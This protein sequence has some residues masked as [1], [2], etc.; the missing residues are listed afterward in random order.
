MMKQPSAVSAEAL[1]DQMIED[2]PTVFGRLVYL[3]AMLD[4]ERG[5]YRHPILSHLRPSTN[6]DHIL[7]RA[8]GQ[9]FRRWL[10][11]NLRQQQAEITRYFGCGPM[12]SAGYGALG[13]TLLR[14]LRD[15]DAFRT[16]P[17]PEAADYERALFTSNMA[18]TTISG[19]YR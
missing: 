4:L 7:R 18:V 17:P 8:H 5:V 2:I 10:E 3:A 6:I 9:I 19:L 1:L 16:L 12:G 11:L 13:P 15:S 14:Q